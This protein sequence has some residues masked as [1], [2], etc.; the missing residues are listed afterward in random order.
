MFTKFPDYLKFFSQFSDLDL[1][2]IKENKRLIKH[3]VK[4]ID[5]VTFVV[6]SIGDETK[7]DELNNA[8]VNLVRSHLKRQIGLKEFRNLGIVLIDFVCDINNRGS[9]KLALDSDRLISGRS[10]DAHSDGGALSASS[11]QDSGTMT[12]A[13]D[14]IRASSSPSP[15]SDDENLPAQSAGSGM[16]T[17]VNGASDVANGDESREENIRRDRPASQ[18]H[19]QSFKVSDGVKSEHSNL[20]TS[21]TVAAWTKLYGTILDLVKQEEDRAS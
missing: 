1:E 14:K 6:D 7:T 17:F 10:N 12:S 11:S 15:S 2:S 21:L 19:H 5:T 16:D 4:V 9:A 20:N 18:Y 3:A 8:L 13:L